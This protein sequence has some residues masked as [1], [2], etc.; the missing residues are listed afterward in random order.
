M[1]GFKAQ[2]FYVNIF[3]NL[4]KIGSILS[5]D[6]IQRSIFPTK[7]YST[8]SPGSLGQARGRQDAK[9]LRPSQ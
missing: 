6:L 2:F 7:F 4:L 9:L 5:S 1:S 8:T 3:S